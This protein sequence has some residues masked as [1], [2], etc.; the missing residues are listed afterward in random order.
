[1]TDWRTVLARSASSKLTTTATTAAAGALALTLAVPAHAHPGHGEE[2]S[3][4]HATD[5]FGF[6]LM[7]AV[8]VGAMAW[9][10]GRK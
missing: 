3:H 9:W 6:A 10:R 2:G 5:L 1:M 8:A 4:W 7:L